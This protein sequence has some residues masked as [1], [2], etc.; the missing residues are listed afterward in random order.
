MHRTLPWITL[1]CVVALPAMAIGPPINT[2]TPISL[3]FAGRGVRTFVKVSRASRDPLDGQV[4][5][6][7]IPVVVP[8]NVTTAGVVGIIVPSIFKARQ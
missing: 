6:T 1:C 8:Y 4:T 5:T 7:L 3:G 2:D